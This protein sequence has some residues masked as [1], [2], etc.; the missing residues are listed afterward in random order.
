VVLVV[1]EETGGISYFKDGEKISF[2]SYKDLYDI[3]T[4]DMA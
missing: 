2:G 1:S 3:I 4:K